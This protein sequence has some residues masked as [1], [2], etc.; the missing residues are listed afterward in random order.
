MASM[1]DTQRDIAMARFLVEYADGHAVKHC[2]QVAGVDRVTIWRW[3]R[4]DPEFSEAFD[5]AQDDGSDEY[6]E[7]LFTQARTGNVAA[8]LGALRMRG[9]G[10]ITG[11]VP[12]NN[13]F[14]RNPSDTFQDDSTTV[15]EL[16]QHARDLGYIIPPADPITNGASH[17]AAD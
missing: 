3:R 13:P 7:L 15:E 12:P 9:R 4:I 8:I 16:A 11:P 17:H 10:P 2:A 5:L 14:G 6:E 1:T